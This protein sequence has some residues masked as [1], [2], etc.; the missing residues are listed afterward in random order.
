M[1]LASRTLSPRGLKI[2]YLV[3]FPLLGVAAYQLFTES[4]VVAAL[5]EWLEATTG[6]SRKNAKLAFAM[7]LIPILAIA[8]GPAYL[9]DYI[10][11]LGLFAPPQPKPKRPHDPLRDW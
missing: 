2:F 6:P 3:A 1:D 10:C 11:K 9:H 7:T 8:S 5:T 4:G